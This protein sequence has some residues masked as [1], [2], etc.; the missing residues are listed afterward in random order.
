MEELEELE[1]ELLLELLDALEDDTLE[2]L[3]LLDEETLL[4]LELLE[5]ELELL[6]DELDSSSSCRARSEILNDTSAP[7]AVN[8]IRWLLASVTLKPASAT[9]NL[10]KAPW[11]RKAPPVAAVCIPI[12]AQPLVA[13]GSTSSRPDAPTAFVFSTTIATISSIA[14][15]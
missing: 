11:P 4:E 15:A 8:L 1:F 5:D 9:C 2:L 3:E 13:S 6:L 12:G 14:I 7:F 10:H